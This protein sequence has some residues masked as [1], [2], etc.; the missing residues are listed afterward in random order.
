[1]LETELDDVELELTDRADDFFVPGLLNE[2][3]RQSFVGQLHETLIKLLGLERIPVDHLL[4]YF[5]REPGNAREMKGFP[6]GERIA[7]LEVAGVVQSNDIARIGLFNRAFGDFNYNSFGTSGDASASFYGEI[8]PTAGDRS[9]ENDDGDRADEEEENDAANDDAAVS[10]RRKSPEGNNRRV[11]RRQDDEESPAVASPAFASC[12]GSDDDEGMEIASSD[13]HLQSQFAADPEASVAVLPV[14]ELERLRDTNAAA[15]DRV[16]PRPLEPHTPGGTLVSLSGCRQT[17]AGNE[18]TA[19]SAVDVVPAPAFIRW[20]PRELETHS[21]QLP[22]SRRRGGAKASKRAPTVA[23]S[24]PYEWR[25]LACTALTNGNRNCSECGTETSAGACRVFLGQLRKLQTAELAADLIARVA[26]SVTVLH[27]E[28]HTNAG[29]G[30][31]KGCAWAYLDSA[32]DAH[33]LVAA[34]HRRAFVDIDADGG[35]GVWYIPPPA[36]TGCSESADQAA[37]ATLS[38]FARIRVEEHQQEG[39]EHTSEQQ[40]YDGSAAQRSSFLMP[41]QPVVA[42]IPAGSLL[43]KLGADCFFDQKKEQ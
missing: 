36:I 17:D 37:L 35:E 24:V 5:G 8:S 10:K 25:C 28:S 22:R 41:R 29:S 33:A 39:E 43:D 3:L 40:N 1:M 31:T 42:E 4:Y 11:Q 20:T 23:P 27:V 2:E 7:D 19:G 14:E 9:A 32:K 30:R 38:E 13:E 16:A 21:L 26:P 15:V 12:A 34:L 6:L 18:A